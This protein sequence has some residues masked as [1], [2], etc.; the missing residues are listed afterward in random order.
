MQTFR[1]LHFFVYLAGMKRTLTLIALLLAL[2]PA[3][4]QVRIVHKGA[5]TGSFIPGHPGGTAAEKEAID[6][7]AHFFLAESLTR[8][9]PWAKA[10]RKGDI[11]LRETDTEEYGEDGCRIVI[12]NRNVRIYGHGKGLVYGTVEFL[13]RYVGI[14][15]WGAG[16][17]YEP[18]HKEL[19]LDP[20]DTVITPTFRYRQSQNY[21]LRTDPLYK[22]WYHLEEPSEVFVANYWV[23]TCNRLLPASRYG[24]EHPEYYAYYNG[25]RNPG[26]ASQWCMSNPEVLEIVCQRLDSLFK[27]YPDRKMIS[28]SQ[29]DGSDTYCRCPECTR[30]MEAPASWKRKAAPPARSSASSTPWRTGS[31]TRRYRPSPTS[32]PSSR[33]GRRSPA[34]T[35]PSCCATSTAAGRRP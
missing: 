25:K 24:A 34:R 1:G 30:I 18:L 15:Y 5:M 35:C 20:V 16:E 26:S 23:H 3:A 19:V 11:V 17:S 13:K 9:A 21:L 29:N 12:D 31:R 27:A 10:I 4:A 22:T 28:I 14:D 32:S 8:T 33:P 7:A 6:L 2:L